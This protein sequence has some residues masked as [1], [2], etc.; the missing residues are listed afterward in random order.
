MSDLTEKTYI[1]NSEAVLEAGT[2][3][4]GRYKIK[5]KVGRGGFSIVYDAEDTQTGR[6]VAVKECTI[7]SEKDRFLREAKLL[8]DF[9]GEEAVV[10]VL[11][12]FE[13]RGTAYI[14][15]EYLD[16]ETLRSN[17]ERSGRWDI[18]DAIRRMSPV[19]KAL[20][21][22]HEKGVIHRD[23]SP[24]NLMVMEDGRLILLDFGAARQYEDSTLSRL[25]VKASYS[26]PEQ[27]DAK[28]I[29][30]S[31]SDVYSVCAAI[32][33]CITGS[34][35][36]DAISRLMLDELKKPSELG[37][38]ILP[39]AEK[40][41]MSGMALDSKERIKS[42]EQ[43]RTELEKTYPPLS[44][45]EK[46]ALK[47]KKRIRI[48]AAALAALVAIAAVLVIINIDTV[49]A[50]YHQRKGT[51]TI[52]IDG[53]AMD[54][55]EF[56]AN[57]AK[58]EA[59]MDALSGG[60]A[61][62]ERI[63]HTI[64]MEVPAEVFGDNDPVEFADRLI[65]APL[66]MCI[67]SMDYCAFS[68]YLYPSADIESVD[69]AGRDLLLGLS[70]AGQSKFSGLASDDSLLAAEAVER[71]ENIPYRSSDDIPGYLIFDCEFENDG[72]TVRLYNSSTDYALQLFT[73]EPLTEA[74]ATTAAMNVKWE[75]AG[76][77]EEVRKQ[78]P[79]G[80]VLRL[81]YRIR[82]YRDWSRLKNKRYA[83]E[84][85]STMKQRMDVLGIPYAI[86]T[87]LYEKGLIIIEVP[88]GSMGLE[89]AV[90]LGG[91]MYMDE[92]FLGGAKTNNN[93]EMLWITG[94]GELSTD[95]ADGLPMISGDVAA[96]AGN[97]NRTLGYLENLKRVGETDLYLMYSG[98][99]LAKTGI[100]DA[101]AEIENSDGIQFS[102]WCAAR[103]RDEEV[104]ELVDFLVRQA[105]ATQDD[106]LDGYD[107]YCRLEDMQDIDKSGNIT[108]YEKA[109]DIVFEAEK[110]ASEYVDELNRNYDG[111]MTFARD[112]FGLKIHTGEI[113]YGST[114][115]VYD[116][117]SYKSSEA[118]AEKFCEF[119]RD[120]KAK[121]E[122]GTFREIHYH[123]RGSYFEIHMDSADNYYL[124]DASGFEGADIEEML[125]R[126]S[127]LKH[128]Y[129]ED[130]NVW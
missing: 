40:T 118:A 77:E 41:L 129:T 100:D 43:L 58:A 101:K 91:P 57:A 66:E 42:M 71:Y 117:S 130:T 122:D 121:L 76:K 52:I 85:Y 19:M 125:S 56:E 75:D 116:R 34:N 65:S 54:D 28:G 88:G 3:L 6:R 90:L 105:G 89:K 29:F 45:E 87:G 107:V 14:V 79:D 46:R 113:D 39:A 112:L 22:M 37:A 126:D 44:P 70:E 109:P 53:T 68:D 20:G 16:G 38:K 123:I 36:E 7:R 72:K 48:A 62:Y 59:R 32:Y 115:H 78:S 84:V 47:I 114:L 35:P 119:Y 4:A 124:Y 17:I 74:F 82:E 51:E 55:E 61:R 73:E 99:P 8:G 102:D 31:W 97:W 108:A 23:I 64:V 110:R 18:E 128:L 9:A 69:M 94:M 93:S 27:M 67:G 2:V 33:F 81:K 50:V 80:H 49:R 111:T 26:P 21:R 63:G 98:I 13:E 60:T 11:D 106:S 103:G 5:E 15:M 10:T 30:G 120:N 95:N 86:G 25:V 104:K 12:F 127:E 24:D 96:D 92:F 1:E 83:E